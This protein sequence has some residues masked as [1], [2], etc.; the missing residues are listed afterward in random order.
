MVHASTEPPRPV[1]TAK[2]KGRALLKCP[3]RPSDGH[4]LAVEDQLPRPK[5]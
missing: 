2:S 5:P 4:C 1:L 3:G